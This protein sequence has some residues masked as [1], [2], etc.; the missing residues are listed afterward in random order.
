MEYDDKLHFQLIG[1]RVHDFRMDR[2]LTQEGLAEAAE[3]SVPYVSHIERRKRKPAFQPLSG[4]P[5]HWGSRWIPYCWCGSL[6]CE[7][8][9][10][11]VPVPEERCAHSNANGVAV[12]F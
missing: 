6:M 11:G 7:F 4:L 5:L 12:P 10:N 9:S 8:Q 3:L 1:R 2:G